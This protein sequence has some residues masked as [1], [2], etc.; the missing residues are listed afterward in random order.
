MQVLRLLR[1][2]VICED[3]NEIA[4]KKLE[5]IWQQGNYLKIIKRTRE[6]GVTKN[7][8]RNEPQKGI[9]MLSLVEIYVDFQECS[10]K[11]KRFW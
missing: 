1:F 2:N 3:E 4:N 7:M 11:R 5:N 6:K 9:E 8:W 10:A